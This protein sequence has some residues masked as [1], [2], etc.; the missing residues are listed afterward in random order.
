MKN[1]LLTTAIVFSSG[2]LYAQPGS[3]YARDAV[4]RKY[5]KDNAG[6]KAKGEAWLQGMMNGKTESS[7]HFTEDLTMHV[8]TYKGG[9]VK[10]ENDIRYYLSPKEKYFGMKP[11]GSG[12]RKSEDMFMIYDNKN[13][14]MVTLNEDKKTG[15]AININSFMSAEA[16]AKRNDPS[17]AS[18]SIKCNKTGKTKTIQGY[19]CFE[20]VCT[21]EDRNTRTEAWVTTAVNIDI[22]SSFSRGP[23]AY[24]GNTK[25]GGF[26]MEGNFYKN[27]ELQTKMEVTSINTKADVTKN[28]SDY[29]MG[30]MR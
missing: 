26:L 13:N 17:G 14:S 23:M 19:S 25:T 8:T 3:S 10:D 11:Q 30:G 2:L 6:N 28:I 15:M 7:Y 22:S 21:D 16:Q 9:E 1:L 20:F 12:R 27:N 18:K 5:E 4:E 29:K 24:F